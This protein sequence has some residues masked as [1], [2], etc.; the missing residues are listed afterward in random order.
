MSKDRVR[1]RG[2]LPGRRNLRD[3]INMRSRTLAF[4]FFAAAMLF[5]MV[6]EWS[7]PIGCPRR[8]MTGIREAHLR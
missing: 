7:A 5:S 6:R 3:H 8:E 2:R 4:A 1:K